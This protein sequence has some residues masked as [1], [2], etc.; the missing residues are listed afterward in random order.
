MDGYL[1]EMRICEIQVFINIGLSAIGCAGKCIS[2]QDKAG[3][4]NTP[5]PTRT[6]CGFSWISPRRL[7]QSCDLSGFY[8]MAFKWHIANSICTVQCAEHGALWAYYGP[9]RLRFMSKYALSKSAGA[10]IFITS[11][12][13]LHLTVLACSM[14]WYHNRRI[15]CLSAALTASIESQVDTRCD[16]HF[17]YISGKLSH[18]LGP[19]SWDQVMSN[20]ARHCR[21]M[22]GW[23]QGLDDALVYV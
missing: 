23:S 9:R 2:T 16:V 19:P 7:V 20:K 14:P 11:E 13:I 4:P 18:H 21:S 5:R 17:R 3:I 15:D 10:L 8:L 12:G 6:Y 1:P 22:A